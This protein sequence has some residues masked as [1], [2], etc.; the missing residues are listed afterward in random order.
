MFVLVWERDRK[1]PTERNNAMF[2]SP[3]TFLTRRTTELCWALMS[4]SHST[5]A[6]ILEE[7]STG[8]SVHIFFMLHFRYQHAWIQHLHLSAYLMDDS[9]K[10]WFFFLLFF[11]SHSFNASEKI[12]VKYFYSNKLHSN[13]RNTN[14]GDIT[15]LHLW[16]NLLLVRFHVVLK[17]VSV[18]K[19]KKKQSY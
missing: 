11:V 5:H 10:T 6:F 3:R 9:P 18:N 2:V 8:T 13:L 14:Y 17:S 4:H 19:Q 12:T 16:L 15:S 7:R 1:S